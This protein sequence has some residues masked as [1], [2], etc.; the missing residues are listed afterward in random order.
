MTLL[1]LTIILLVLLFLIAV[2]GIGASAWKS[3]ADRS[4]CIMNIRKV[5]M[6]TRS[7]QHYFNLQEGATINLDNTVLGTGRY[8]DDPEC[9]GGGSYTKLG[10]IPYSGELAITCSL[11][12]TQDHEP[13]NYAS[14]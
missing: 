3:G 2:V 11:V 1:E 8:V 12:S 10:H 14:W 13:D 5:Q 4:S 7:Y 6:A 9:P